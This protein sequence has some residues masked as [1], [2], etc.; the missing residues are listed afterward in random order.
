MPN[1]RQRADSSPP[2]KRT[3]KRRTKKKV[4]TTIPI[5]PTVPPPST[6]EETTDLPDIETTTEQPDIET[7]T[8]LP[9]IDTRMTSSHT[10]NN[11]E[12]IDEIT[13]QVTKIEIVFP[14]IDFT[15]DISNLNEHTK[16]IKECNQSSAKDF[17]IYEEAVQTAF[18]KLSIASKITADFDEVIEGKR[19]L[20]DY[21]NAIMT[22]I[23]NDTLAGTASAVT[24]GARKARNF[25]MTWNLLSAAWPQE[26]THMKGV[27]MRAQLNSSKHLIN[28]IWLFSM[29]PSHI[30]EPTMAQ[31]PLMIIFPGFL[32]I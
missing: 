30:N 26:T 7:T 10:G 24:K 4:Q 13:E 21:S 9:D 27:T 32:M 25:V 12:Q 16:Y 15:L 31:L 1:T 2:T 11:D 28:D 23:M 20:S 6:N 29:K 19:S 3:P 22:L 14:A 5:L 8:D 17:R 18:T